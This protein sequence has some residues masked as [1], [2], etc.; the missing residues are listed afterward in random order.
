MVEFLDVPE[1]VYGKVDLSP[2]ARRIAVHVADVRDHIWI[3]DL[4]RR[5]GR[6]VASAMPEGYPV[7]SPD[8]RRLAGAAVARRNV[9]VHEVEPNGAVAA[10]TVLDDTGRGPMAWSPRSEVLALGRFPELRI[11]FLGFGGAVT[12]APF[13]GLFASFSPDGRWLAYQSN[14]GSTTE[15][16]IR[17]FPEGRLVGQVST[18]GGVE[19]L[20]MASGELFYRNGRRW[21]ST[22][23]ST[24]PEPRWDPPR[25]TF[26][27]EF[28]DTS[29]VSYDVSPDG[30]RLLVVK[31]VQPLT[32]SRISLLVNWTARPGGD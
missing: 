7:W 15:V 8:G 25:V 21:L 32:T 13:A 1:R 3:W 17:S 20:W 9:I 4:A 5:E 31:R 10:G 6:R 22:H 19:P 16:Y 11:E 12:A 28:V 24:S 27:T 29:G 2:D 14:Q 30:S 26:D 18:G 23:V